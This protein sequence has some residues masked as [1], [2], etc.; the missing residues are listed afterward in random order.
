MIPILLTSN[1]GFAG[2]TFFALGFALKLIDLGYKISYMKPIGKKPI[3]KGRGLFS[4]GAMFMRE[5]LHLSDNI[6]DMSPFV[7]SFETQ[8]QLFEGNIED[9]KAKIVKAFNNFSD[10]DFLLLGGGNNFFEGISFGVDAYSIAKELNAKVLLVEAWAGDLSLD[11]VLGSAKYFD[12]FF[13][14]AVINKVPTSILWYVKDKVAPYIEKNGVRI[15]G[16]FPKDSLLEAVT[17]R[18]LVEILN[19]GVICCEDKLDELVEN[20]SVGA[21]DVDNALHFFRRTPNKAVITGV[22]RPD[23][24]IAALE[25]STK[26]II[27]T[28]GQSTSDFVIGKA[29][30]LGVPIISVSDDTYTT[31]DKIEKTVGKARLNEKGKVAKAKELVDRNFDIDKF[32]KCIY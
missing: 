19:G 14:G 4:S 11:N 7:L 27:L 22:H 6:E 17:V 9:V 32:M 30:S 25:T 24:Q 20:F 12:G 16:V 10:K 5:A 26:C 2:K 23:I 13:A 18:H 21:M 28:G 15:F 31:I 29:Q 1:S 8:N 3:K